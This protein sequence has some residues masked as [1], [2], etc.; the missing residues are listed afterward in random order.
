MSDASNKQFPMEPVQVSIAGTYFRSEG[1]A[2]Q[3]LADN[4]ITWHEAVEHPLTNLWQISE[5]T[6]RPNTLTSDPPTIVEVT[7]VKECGSLPL[8]LALEHVATFEH[9]QKKMGYTP[10][11]GM[12]SDDLGDEHV[13]SFAG[14][15]GFVLDIYNKPHVAQ[16]GRPVTKGFFNPAT[17]RQAQADYA[18]KPADKP[19]LSETDLSHLFRDAAHGVD[20]FERLLDRRID[21]KKWDD[22]IEKASNVVR[23]LAYAQNTSYETIQVPITW[24][25]RKEEVHRGE[26]E[27]RQSM[28]DAKESLAKC[29]FMPENERNRMLK[30]FL[31]VSELAF[32]VG[33]AKTVFN[34]MDRS[35]NPEN[36]R[37]KVREATTRAIKFAKSIGAS[38][39]DEK[40]INA[41]II[42][43]QGKKDLNDLITEKYYPDDEKAQKRHR[44]SYDYSARD[45][46]RSSAPDVIFMPKDI[47]DIM[48]DMY[49]TRERIKEALDIEKQRIQSAQAGTKPQGASGSNLDDGPLG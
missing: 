2:H 45:S 7:P 41:T 35:D 46:Y 36:H 30:S 28:K 3:E 17:I 22:F 24:G 13:K 38:D 42:D 6:Q 19:K 47:I 26:P 12:K 31:D 40:R 49:D 25:I 23:Y 15:N 27:F 39:Q 33:L 29:T 5:V 18:R 21:I 10:S 44:S 32:Y 37:A 4:F 20:N 14:L 11:K 43:G 9:A 8:R 16:E 48:N 34:T 1:L